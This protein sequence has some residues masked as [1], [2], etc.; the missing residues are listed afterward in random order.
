MACAAT[1]AEIA[2]LVCSGAVV[3]RGM[4]NP[5]AFLPD[6]TFVATLVESPMMMKNEPGKSEQ[7]KHSNSNH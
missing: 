2:T 7:R 3:P 5:W 6:S 4:Q 1:Q